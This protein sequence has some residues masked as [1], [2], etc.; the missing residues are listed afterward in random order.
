MR[1]IYSWPFNLRM[2]SNEQ[3]ADTLIWLASTTPGVDWVSGGYYSRRKPD[4]CRGPPPTPTWPAS[5]GTAAPSWSPRSSEA[6][7]L[8]GPSGRPDRRGIRIGT[9]PRIQSMSIDQD[10]ANISAEAFVQLTTFRRNG[11]PVATPVWI[12]TDSDGA[13]IITTVDGTGKV[14]RLRHTPEVLLRP[15][16]RRGVVE[17]GAPT[18]RANATIVDDRDQVARVVEAVQTK[19]G[20]EYRIFMIIERLVARRARPRVILRLDALVAQPG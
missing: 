12:A 10:A 17:P 7:R 14:K 11:E 19:Y 16:S 5:C 9:G 4:R 20:L 15:C 8:G 13:P 1:L 18:V 6:E 3:G 2:I